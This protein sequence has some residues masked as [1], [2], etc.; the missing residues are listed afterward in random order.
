MP[1]FLD[2]V[3]Q[4]PAKALYYKKDQ[5]AYTFEK[6]IGDYLRELPIGKRI[7]PNWQVNVFNCMSFLVF[8]SHM[9]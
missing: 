9:A 4:T 1:F 8:F 7:V 3:P 6:V 5:T 2:L